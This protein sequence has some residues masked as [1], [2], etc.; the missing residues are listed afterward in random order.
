MRVEEFFVEE[1][2][3]CLEKEVVRGEMDKAS[4]VRLH[5]VVHQYSLHIQSKP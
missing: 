3:E 2:I 1:V 4:W 5:L